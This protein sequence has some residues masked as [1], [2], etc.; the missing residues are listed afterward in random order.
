MEEP[1]YRMKLMSMYGGITMDN[2][3]KEPRIIYL[4]SN[5]AMKTTA[6]RYNKPFL[7]HFSCHYVVDDH[8]IIRLFSCTSEV[9]IVLAYRCFL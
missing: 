8:T 4:D 5:V 1:E 6:F 7:N 9:N 3:Q 2:G